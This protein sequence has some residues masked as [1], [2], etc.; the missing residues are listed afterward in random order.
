MKDEMQYFEN[1]KFTIKYYISDYSV[2]YEITHKKS[3]GAFAGNVPKEL[4][5]FLAEEV[6]KIDKVKS[7]EL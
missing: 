5:L 2:S 4:F 3:F 6:K 7:E 1:D